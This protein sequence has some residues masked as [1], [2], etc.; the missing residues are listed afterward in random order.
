M[1]GRTYRR[2]ARSTDEWLRTIRI[3][4]AL[5]GWNPTAASPLWPLGLQ[6]LSDRGVPVPPVH[7]SLSLPFP[8]SPLYH[9]VVVTAETDTVGIY[10]YSANCSPLERSCGEKLW[11]HLD[12]FKDQHARSLSHMWIGSFREAS[13]GGDDIVL[14]DT[15]GKAYRLLSMVHVSI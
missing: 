6:S 12:R 7:P 2:V 8:E 11:L 1:V 14:L 13:K 5:N 15:H 9:T 4:A 3:G 10:R